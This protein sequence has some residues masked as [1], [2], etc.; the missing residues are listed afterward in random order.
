MWEVLTNV[1]SLH[2]RRVATIFFSKSNDAFFENH[3]TNQF[4]F[5][6]SWPKICRLATLECFHKQNQINFSSSAIISKFWPQILPF[7]LLCELTFNVLSRQGRRSQSIRR[8]RCS[9]RKERNDQNQRAIGGR[10]K[11]LPCHQVW[12]FVTKI[13][14]TYC[15]KKLF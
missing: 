6:K 4:R 2:T 5:F 3:F 9:R 7:F 12:Y 14:L 15:E 11:D 13:V 1:L 10:E 8:R